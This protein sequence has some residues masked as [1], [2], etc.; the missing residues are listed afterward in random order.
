MFMQNFGFLASIQTNLGKFLTFFQA[1]LRI[2]QEKSSANFKKIM[3]MQNFNYPASIQ[4][5]LDTFLTF[6]PENP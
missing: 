5:D 2:L 4:T 6:F 1:K 3:F